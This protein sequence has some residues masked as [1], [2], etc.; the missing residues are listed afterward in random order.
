M[1]VGDVEIDQLFFVQESSSHPVILGEPYIGLVGNGE[2]LEQTVLPVVGDFGSSTSI[3]C[4]DEFFE[5]LSWLRP[6]VS[7]RDYIQPVIV[8]P[9]WQA[10]G[11][12]L[13]FWRA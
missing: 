3:T 10:S 9:K 7:S 5:E 11:L 6:P 4:L 12:S 8:T 1:K 13:H 2:W